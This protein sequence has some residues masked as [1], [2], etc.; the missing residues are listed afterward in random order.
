MKIRTGYVSNSSSSSYT[1]QICGRNECGYDLGLRDIEMLQCECGTCYCEKHMMTSAKVKDVLEVIEEFK[2]DELADLYEKLKAMNPDDVFSENTN[3]EDWDDLVYFFKDYCGCDEMP[4]YL[5]PVCNMEHIMTEDMLDYVLHEC[6]LE[7][8][9]VENEMKF[10][11]QKR[12][13]LV[14]F[15]KGEE[16]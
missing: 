8:D 7:K 11:F 15:L 14:N 1:C 5:C 2:N 9:R 4:K 6:N 12:D 10:R 16:K 3:K 13:E